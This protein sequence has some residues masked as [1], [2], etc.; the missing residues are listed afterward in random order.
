MQALSLRIR[1][2]EWVKEL[3]GEGNIKF[4]NRLS[5][6]KLR[7]VRSNIIHLQAWIIYVPV[8]YTICA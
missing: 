4:L 2:Q 6:N 8:L 5:A 3:V 1:I 7:T